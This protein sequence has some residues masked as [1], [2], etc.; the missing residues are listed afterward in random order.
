MLSMGPITH[1]EILLN[2]HTSMLSGRVGNE[3]ENVLFRYKK[4]GKEKKKRHFDLTQCFNN[5]N[6]SVSGIGNIV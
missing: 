1:Q 3:S 6:K 5:S 4:K 2:F